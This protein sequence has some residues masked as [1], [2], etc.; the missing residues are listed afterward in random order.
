MCRLDFTERS[1]VAMMSRNEPSYR[2]GR[3][4]PRASLRNA[5][6]KQPRR[7]PGNSIWSD[8]CREVQTSPKRTRGVPGIPYAPVVGGL[9]CWC[10][11]WWVG[12][13]VGGRG[14]GGAKSITS[15]AAMMSRNEPSYRY[16]RN[17]PRASLRNAFWKQPRHTAQTG[18]ICE[19]H[20][21][22]ANLTSGAAMMS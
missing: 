11:G 9:V 3:N 6:W 4:T 10:V 22:R 19:A 2:Y 7:G 20:G 12:G 13:S 8:P 18:Q 17:T 14:G 15:G 16:G 1:T 21:E 5:F